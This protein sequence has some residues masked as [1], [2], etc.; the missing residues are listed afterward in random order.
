M[1]WLLLGAQFRVGVTSEGE[2]L[3]L[4]FLKDGQLAATVHVHGG[5]GG[6]FFRGVGRT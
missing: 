3:A 5:F 4:I 6:V 1:N 2:Q